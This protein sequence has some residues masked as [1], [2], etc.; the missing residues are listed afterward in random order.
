MRQK[1]ITPKKYHFKRTLTWYCLNSMNGSQIIKNG[2]I[3]AILVLT[4]TITERFLG[5]MSRM[6]KLSGTL[7]RWTFYKYAILSMERRKYFRCKSNAPYMTWGKGC[8]RW[9]TKRLWSTT[10]GYCIT[11][12]LYQSTLQMRSSK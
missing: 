8:K 2:S 12:S 6:K 11:N 4:K 9:L 3:L 1:M 10:I 5:F 7:L